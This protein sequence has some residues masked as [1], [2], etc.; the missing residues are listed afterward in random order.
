MHQPPVILFDGICNLCC[1]WVRF[2][3]RRDKNRKFRFAS[4][5]S[6]AGK[7]LLDS[8][9]LS[10]IEPETIVY[11]K[12]KQFYQESSAVLEILS[13]LGGMWKA[14]ALFQLIPK[15]VRNGIYRFIARN[16]Y[17]IFGTRSSCL[18]PTPENAKR[19]LL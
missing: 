5:Q 11:L 4:I 18:M 17:R 6:D 1:G 13:D 12:D 19:F 3:I 16:R 7:K 2:L 15:A 10:H 9:G 8:A 14:A